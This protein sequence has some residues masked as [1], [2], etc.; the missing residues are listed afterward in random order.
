MSLFPRAALTMSSTMSSFVFN[1]INANGTVSRKCRGRSWAR[2]TKEITQVPPGRYAA[3]RRTTQ[4]GQRTRLICSDA[5]RTRG[6]WGR[7]IA[8]LVTVRLATRV[9]QA[10][11][12]DFPSEQSADVANFACNARGESFCRGWSRERNTVR[13]RRPIGHEDSA[14][15]NGVSDA[16]ISI[17]ISCQCEITES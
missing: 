1:L 7:R 12:F 9:T 11:N 6:T 14:S 8:A 13:L 16:R 3:A 17:R 5:C 10:R 2:L 4:G 15:V